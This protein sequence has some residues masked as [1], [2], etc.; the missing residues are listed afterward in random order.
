MHAASSCGPL[1][2]PNS[3]EQG[4]TF[5]ATGAEVNVL[6][7]T[8]FS[9]GGQVVCTANTAQPTSSWSTVTCT[10]VGCGALAIPNSD[11]VPVLQATAG[12]SLSYTCNEGFTL[13]ADSYTS[14]PL[15]PGFA[16]ILPPFRLV[17]RCAWPLSGT[18]PIWM[19]ET[20][21]RTSCLKYFLCRLPW[22]VHLLAVWRVFVYVYVGMCSPAL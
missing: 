8:G 2:V 15:P 6:C 3:N 22:C 10:S 18:S 5:G 21:E 4:F 16:S 19:F 12:T 11:F 20:C 13:G 7:N 1:T 9:G 14:W 17:A